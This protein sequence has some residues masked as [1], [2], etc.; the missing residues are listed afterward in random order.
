M[1]FFKG[2]ENVKVYCKKLSTADK[3]TVIIT[4]EVFKRKKQTKLTNKELNI[5]HRVASYEYETIK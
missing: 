5:I 2:Q 4:V 3:T 1:K